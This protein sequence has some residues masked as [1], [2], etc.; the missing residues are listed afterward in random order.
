[1]FNFWSFFI[2][3]RN[4]SFLLIIALIGFGFNSLFSIPKESTPEVQI[5]VGIVTTIL[6]GASAGDIEKLVTNKIEDRL[7][8]NLDDL[9]ELT[10]T[11]KEGVSIIVATFEADADIDSSIQDLKDEVD[12]IT[13]E[14]PDEAEDPFISEINFVN[15]PIMTV[16]ISGNIPIE[17]FIRIAEIVED[18]IKSVRGI[19]NVETG[20]MRERE[21]QVIVNKE[22]LSTF[23]IRLIDVISAIGRSNSTLPVGSVEVDGVSYN[24]SFEGDIEDPSEVRDISIFSSGGEPVYIRDVATVVDGLEEAV[25]FSRVSIESAPSKRALSIS[26]FK[27]SGGD[28]SK[29]ARDVRK[30]VGELQK[31]GEILENMEVLVLFDTGELVEEDLI[32]LSTTGLQTII[33]VMMVLF[34]SLGWRE[35]ILAGLAIPISFLVAFIGLEASGN[36]INFVSLFSLIL[37]IGILVD[38]AIVM[39]EG[40]HT[41]MKEKMDKIKA[42]LRTIFEYHWPLTSGTMTT[43]AVFLPLFLISGITGEFIAT[44]PFTIIF[45]LLASLV[46]ALGFIPIIASFFLR[47]RSVTKLEQLQEKYT[48][49]LR[50]WYEKNLKIIL[51]RK[52]RENFFLGGI[53]LLF[54]ITLSFPMTGLVQVIFFPQEDADNIFIDIEL[55]QGSVLSTSDIEARKVEEILY[56]ED[57]I[58]SF[59]TIVGQSS[60]FGDALLNPKFANVQ[61]TLRKSRRD[62]STEILER[63]RAELLKIHT[64][65][66][67]IFQPSG[68]P[69]T[70][71]PV[72]IS[73]QGNDFAKLNRLA[74]ETKN[75]LTDIPGTVD[76]RTSTK[77]DGTE[78]V[79]RIDRAK[80]SELGLDPSIVAQTLRSAV[81]GSTATTIKTQE[82]DIDVVVKLNLNSSYR[83]A[84]DTNRT[85]IDSVRNLE[86][87]TPQGTVLLGSI[88]DVTI[89]KSSAVIRHKDK[90][91]VVTVSSKLDSSGN[92][93]V[94]LSEFRE[95]LKKISVPD[96]V[97]VVVGGEN[98]EVDQSFKDMGTSLI[99]G[100]IL[101]LTILVLQFNSYRFAI[102]ILS[103]VPFSLIGIFI[104]LL[105]TGKALS[106]PSIL[107]F[108][109][110]SGIVVNNSI[111]LIDVMNKIRERNPEKL[112]EDVVIE[113]ASIRLRPILLTAITTIIGVTP[114]TYASEIWAPLAYSIMF[115][116]AFSVI[117]TLV[118][119]PVIYNRWPGRLSRK[120]SEVVDSVIQL[121]SPKEKMALE[122]PQKKDFT[123]RYFN[124]EN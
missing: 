67:R 22:A 52:K 109:A 100:L 71:D 55:P 111:I 94:V 82:Q 79:L 57:T 84:H 48:E 65:E 101:M 81:S 39:V 31:E 98:E 10:S 83:D 40:I 14:L 56:K 73:L 117:L 59:V 118:L 85:T 50:N 18:E 124:E 6:P 37:A 77:D 3:K 110:L 61:I 21:V 95:R 29:I 66:V 89:E 113:G 99:V 24:I 32:R 102:Y 8:N 38:S 16:A 123:F 115:G 91:R 5:P 116:L 20:G 41:H 13:P 7:S 88:L 23:E 19:S 30:K 96:G 28:I 69:P 103:I 25:T 17:Q 108:I 104:G 107:G 2:K 49:K 75:I 35:A 62:T 119:I 43:V 33:L 63:L 45:V 76:I 105:L 106:F 46:V 68:G 26:V 4:F 92:T 44:I 86:I 114:L 15:Q 80:A 122:E 70:G 51:G 60:P 36:T 47:R 72:V 12:V 87:A 120:K 34:I 1:M 11:S 74:L 78:F 42:S 97:E 90:K 121:H 54:F 112:I 9:N 64:S 53:I 93:F 27:R 58:E